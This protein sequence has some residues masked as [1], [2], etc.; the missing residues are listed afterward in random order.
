MA[1]TKKVFI[2]YDTEKYSKKMIMDD[3]YGERFPYSFKFH[4]DVTDELVGVYVMEADEVWT[5]GEVSDLPTFKLAIQE[6]K[7][8]WYMA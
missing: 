7:D 8:I 5:F 1:L 4:T 2:V 6:G 3:L